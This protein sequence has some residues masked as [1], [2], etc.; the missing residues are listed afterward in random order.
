MVYNVTP[1]IF[2]R[3]PKMSGIWVSADIVAVLKKYGNIKE[4]NVNRDYKNEQ[5]AVVHFNEWYPEGME[6]A[7]AV[8]KG[9]VR[10]P[11]LYRKYFNLNIFQTGSLFKV[12]KLIA[13]GISFGNRGQL[14]AAEFIEQQTQ[15]E[16]AASIFIMNF[17]NN[18]N[19]DLTD[20]IMEDDLPPRYYRHHPLEENELI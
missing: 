15:N 17:L 3:L 8:K 13:P 12:A 7:N 2:I 1:S 9:T 11:A 5:V 10:I 18:H 4:V 20:I 14:N 16:I 19:R 6:T